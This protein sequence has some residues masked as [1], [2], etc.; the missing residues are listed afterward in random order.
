MSATSEQII[1]PTQE[2]VAA[3]APEL[4]EQ[5]RFALLVDEFAELYNELSPHIDRLEKMK[6]KITD[7]VK[8]LEGEDPVTVFGVNYGIDYTAPSQE[9]VCKL[10]AQDF[11]LTTHCWDAV[12]V[13]VTEARKVLSGEAFDK[14]FSYKLGSRRFKRVRP[15]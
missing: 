8:E 9:A 14:I 6:K 15:L 2:G 7:K 1:K 12:K 11:I 3:M 5:E 10:S 4:S 13:G